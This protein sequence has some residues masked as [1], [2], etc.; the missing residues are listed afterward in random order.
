ML[1][2]FDSIRHMKFKILI[3]TGHATWHVLVECICYY[4]DGEVEVVVTEELKMW[5]ISKLVSWLTTWCVI[6]YK[7]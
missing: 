1:I 4:Q 7:A 6:H 5:K 3:F 2:I